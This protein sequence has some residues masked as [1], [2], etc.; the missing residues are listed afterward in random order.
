MKPIFFLL[1]L[2]L[3]L[4]AI[5]QADE[6]RPA[7]VELTQL[8]GL[9]DQP[10]MEIWQ[11][12]WK[13]SRKSRLG[14]TGKL[15]LPQGCIKS[16]QERRLFTAEVLMTE[17]VVHCRSTIAGQQI[18]LENLEL[19]M[20]E[21]L[22][23][24]TLLDG[25]SHT[26][27]L[28]PDQPTGTIPAET[29]QNNVAWAYTLLGVEHILF[30]Y[31]H[32]LFVLAL[33][34]L[35]R[36]GWLVAQTVTAFTVAHSVT[37][38]GSTLGYLSLP[39]R[40]VEAVIALS[41]VFLAAEIIKA[42]PEMPRLS[43]RY[44]WVVAF[45]FGLLHGFGFA[46]ALAEIGLPKDAVPMALLTFNLGVEIGQLII[47]AIALTGI[48]L[49]GICQQR[50]LRPTRLTLGYSIGVLATYWFLARMLA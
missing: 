29:K 40:P 2:V 10:L 33:V 50:L 9:V 24:I 30:G 15:L 27:R 45:A 18:R 22:V 25:T 13:A 31:D 49:I 16:D 4:P 5:V 21:A 7:Y 48:Y 32:L 46:G 47:V 39:Q 35:L 28:T 23:R 14:Q 3:L 43:E 42:T 44:P 8:P 19:T 6:L 12:R 37:L 38:I 41:I 1:G 17:Q 11:T 36:G 34:L 20:T 26:I